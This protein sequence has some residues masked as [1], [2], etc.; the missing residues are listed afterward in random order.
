MCVFF[1]FLKWTACE[2]MRIV[3]NKDNSPDMYNIA[4]QPINSPQIVHSR[5]VQ[6]V[7]DVSNSKPWSTIC[8]LRKMQNGKRQNGGINGIT[9]MLGSVLWTGLL[10]AHTVPCYATNVC[11]PV[12]FHWNIQ[13]IYRYFNFYLQGHGFCLWPNICRKMHLLF[14]FV[15]SGWIAYV[16]MS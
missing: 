2:W 14:G 6:S 1:F 5:T 15:C 13:T 10:Q 8:K 16:F 3:L 7:E 12:V 11:A 4:H 9:Q